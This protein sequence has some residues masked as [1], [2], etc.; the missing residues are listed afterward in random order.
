MDSLVTAL[1]TILHVLGNIAK[2][3]C[4]LMKDKQGDTWI[5]FATDVG[6]ILGCTIVELLVHVDIEPNSIPPTIKLV[7]DSLGIRRLC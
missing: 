7:M 3:T 6:L 5:Q 1:M 2:T 4:M